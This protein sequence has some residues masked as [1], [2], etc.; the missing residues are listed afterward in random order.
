[1]SKQAVQ[2]LLGQP[3]LRDNFHQNTWSYVYTLIPSRG[4]PK[5]KHLVVNF[6]NGRVAN[7]SGDI[8]NPKLPDKIKKS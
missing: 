5:Q 8:P 4:K 1:M 7:F 6:V 2:N 3:V